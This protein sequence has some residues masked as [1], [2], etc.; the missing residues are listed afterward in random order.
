M[1]EGLDVCRQNYIMFLTPSKGGCEDE[2][3]CSRG[4]DTQQLRKELRKQ[5]D[6]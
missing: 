6:A 4:T 1:E 5:K 2:F 3:S